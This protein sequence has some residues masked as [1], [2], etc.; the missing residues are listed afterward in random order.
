[1]P[2]IIRKEKKKKKSYFERNGQMTTKQEFQIL[3]IH[4]CLS[5]FITVLTIP[6]TKVFCFVVFFPL[7]DQC[8][9]FDFYGGPEGQVTTANCLTICILSVYL[10][11]PH[12]QMYALLYYFY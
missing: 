12:C 5:R 9:A 3:S 4:Y 8:H 7:N 6:E 1:M 2:F 11:F 10:H